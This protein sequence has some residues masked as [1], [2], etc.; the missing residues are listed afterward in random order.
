MILRSVGL[1]E[2]N[3]GRPLVD[4]LK[5]IDNGRIISTGALKV[6]LPGT[7]VPVRLGAADFFALRTSLVVAFPGGLEA[8][9]SHKLA[10][11]PTVVSTIDIIQRDLE[12]I[13][14][15]S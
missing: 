1:S 7:Y 10:K 12:F 5:E 2:V 11:Q 6:K 9:S 4:R 8:L 14:L 15:G 3:E 13:R